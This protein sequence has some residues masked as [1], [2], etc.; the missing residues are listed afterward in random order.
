[1]LLLLLRSRERP[2][3][4]FRRLLQAN[5]FE[6]L[7]VIPTGSLGGLALLEARPV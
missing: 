2:E 4:E 3:S 1:M 5:G 7:R 6:L